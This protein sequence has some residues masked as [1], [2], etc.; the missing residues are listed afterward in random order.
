MLKALKN[1]ASQLQTFCGGAAVETSTL[2]EVM[3]QGLVDAATRHFATSAPVG[4]DGFSRV[5]INLRYP[6]FD[7]FTAQHGDAA[8]TARYCLGF[9]KNYLNSWLGFEPNK[10]QY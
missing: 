1:L 9:W 5:D 10:S 2:K 3:L 6:L 8:S 4:S 7:L